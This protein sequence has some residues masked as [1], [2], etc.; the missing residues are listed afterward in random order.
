MTSTT[1][2]AGRAGTVLMTEPKLYT[3]AELAELMQI[4]ERSVRRHMDKWPHLAISPKTRRFTEKHI[5]A[6]LALH[7]KQPVEHRPSRRRRTV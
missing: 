2:T 6:I 7:E 1:P 5:E 3:P 4:S